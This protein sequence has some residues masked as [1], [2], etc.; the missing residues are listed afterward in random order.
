MRVD[1]SSTI[2][3]CWSIPMCRPAADRLRRRGLPINLGIYIARFGVGTL[4][5]DKSDNPAKTGVRWCP[6]KLASSYVVIWRAREPVFLPPIF[7]MS[8]SWRL[9]EEGELCITE[10]SLTYRVVLASLFCCWYFSQ[11]FL[12]RRRVRRRTEPLQRAHPSTTLKAR[13]SL[14]GR[15]RT[16]SCRRKEA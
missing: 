13:R 15:W 1:F 11:L 8:G 6:R 7:S 10:L 16:C 4:P 14:K 12:E 5:A 3:T 9:L 2:W